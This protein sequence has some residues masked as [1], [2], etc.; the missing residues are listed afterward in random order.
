MKTVLFTLEFPPQIGGIAEYYGALAK[1]WRPVEDFEVITAST[2]PGMGKYFGYFRQINRQKGRGKS[3][4]IVGH[5]FP[6]GTALY[7]YSR[8]HRLNYAVILHGLDFSR[9]TQ[10]LCRRVL[11]R[12]ILAKAGSI[13]CANSY[14][15]KQVA[16]FL[17][18][19]TD[20]IYV[21]NPGASAPD[22]LSEIDRMAGQLK[23][24]L[25]PDSSKVVFSLGRLVAR[26][27]FDSLIK[28]FSRPDY[29]D[30]ILVIAG[31]GPDESRLKQL[32]RGKKNIIFRGR[33]SETEKWAWLKICDF[34][35]LV[36]RDIEGDYEGFGIVYLEAALMGKAVLAGRAGGVSDAVLDQRT[37]I[38]VDGQKQK[39]IDQALDSL[40]ADTKF[41]EKLGQQGKKR[42]EIEF[43]LSRQVNRIQQ[44]LSL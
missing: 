32:A 10:S 6:L 19:G 21:V 12:K 33:I 34:F 20:K 15:Q 24:D 11:T 36:S 42:A 7:L 2:R 23:K 4:F 38:L 14:T 8:F 40:M 25:I 1:F 17:K 44:I 43:S 18:T 27:G 35:A 13:I 39:E 37:G 16:V 41:C 31:T 22:N 9:A 3:R 29:S 30:K 5:I 26:K 28:S